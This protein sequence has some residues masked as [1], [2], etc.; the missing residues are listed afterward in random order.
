M[1]DNLP[2]FGKTA[3]DYRK[4]RHGF[5]D[6]FFTR[7]QRIGLGTNG[8]K[9][10]DLGTGTGTVA[11]GFAMMG[12]SVV[13]I[14]PAEKLIEQAKGIDQELGVPTIDYVVGTAE[15]TKQP[16]HFF[17]VVVAGQCWHWFDADKAIEEI[18]RVLKPDGKLVI[19]HY[20]WVPENGSVPQISEALILKH[21]SGWKM[22]GGNGFYPRWVSQLLDAGFQNIETY[23]FEVNEHYSHE[24][25]RGR[26]RASAGVSASLPQEQVVKF[27]EEHAAPLEQEF[28]E[29][30]LRVPHRCFTIIASPTTFFKPD[31]SVAR[32]TQ[33]RA[34]GD[35]QTPRA[36]L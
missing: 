5:P 36:R 3:V 32:T 17:D 4:Y 35:S 34:D 18:K 11:R 30:P 31:F 28:P 19:A 10:L 21:N 14:D 20:D 2:D 33:R 29:E 13:A 8:Q 7:L 26:I 22:G 9:V 25:W 23:S 24:A 6:E 16:E 15:D 1:P 12:C 27:D